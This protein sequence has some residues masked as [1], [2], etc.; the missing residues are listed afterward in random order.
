MQQLFADFFWL[1]ELCSATTN[2]LLS[3][4]FE[5]FLGSI[6]FAVEAPPSAK[7]EKQKNMICPEKASAVLAARLQNVTCLHQLFALC[8]HCR[9][10]VCGNVSV[11]DFRRGCT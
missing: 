4:W 5:K 8:F 1:A 7:L 10:E 2:A 11:L 3:C 9:N 6:L